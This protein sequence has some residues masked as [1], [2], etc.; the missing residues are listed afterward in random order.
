M[1][2]NLSPRR[3]APERTA[4]LSHSVTMFTTTSCGHFIRLKRQLDEAGIEVDLVDVDRHR[5]HSDRIVTATGGYRVVPTIDVGGTLLVN[6]SLD[7][8]RAALAAI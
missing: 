4:K 5:E 3:K 6:P 8:V 2:P 7:E 1:A